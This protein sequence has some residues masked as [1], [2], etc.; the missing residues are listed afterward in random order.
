MQAGAWPRQTPH[1]VGTS[2]QGLGSR[3]RDWLHWPRDPTQEMGPGAGG[4]DRVRHQRR[5]HTPRNPCPSLMAQGLFGQTGFPVP[6]PQESRVSW[7]HWVG[8]Q[9]P[10]SAWRYVAR[11]LADVDKLILRFTRGGGQRPRLAMATSRGPGQRRRH[12]LTLHLLWSY[13]HRDGAGSERKTAA[14][15][16]AESRPRRLGHSSP[17]KEPRQSVGQRRSL[18][19]TPPPRP[20]S[21]RGA[22]A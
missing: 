1:S 7:S 21:R 20:T 5:I 18:R 12:R 22:R 13:G 14:R 6:P 10:W 4:Q 11:A 8:W 2:A 3:L 19:Q 17:V 16:R 9:Q 15:G